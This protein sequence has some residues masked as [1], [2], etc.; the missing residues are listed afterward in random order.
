MHSESRVRTEITVG[1]LG[2]TQLSLQ[3]PDPFPELIAL[4]GIT[5]S[6]STLGL[7]S[8]VLLLDSDEIED[9]VEYPGKDEGEEEG[10][11]GQVH[12]S[13]AW[14]GGKLRGMRAD[15]R[16]ERDIQFRWA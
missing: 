15:K 14:L 4:S 7:Q 13:S 5:T 11:S 2:F 8:S 1:R 6:S 9:N 3:L 10:G 16:H 12:C